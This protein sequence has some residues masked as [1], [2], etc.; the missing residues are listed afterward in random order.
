MKATLHGQYY[1]Q[2]RKVLTYKVTGTA[3]EVETYKAIQEQQTNRAADSWP[4][5]DGAPLYFLVPSV[6]MRNG[7]MPQKQYNLIFNQDQTKVIRDTSAQDLDMY[8]SVR[9]AKIKEMGRI[10]AE[11]EMGIGVDRGTTTVAAPATPAIAKPVG[12]PKELVD[13]VAGAAADIGEDIGHTE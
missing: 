4:E 2:G 8:T 9:E 3:V 12:E 10:S 1:K 7:E 13:E 11:R 5:V 6:L